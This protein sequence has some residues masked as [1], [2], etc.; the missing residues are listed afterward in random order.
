MQKYIK[1]YA[2]G[3]GVT[4]ANIKALINRSCFN[5][6]NQCMQ[7]EV[8]AQYECSISKDHR[9]AVTAFVEKRKPIFTGK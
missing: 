2:N 9:E 8:S 7:N 4:Y 1:K 3:P 6:L 5:D